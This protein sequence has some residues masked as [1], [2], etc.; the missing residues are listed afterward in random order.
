MHSGARAFFCPIFVVNSLPSLISHQTKAFY[1]YRY[2]EPPAIS[3]SVCPRAYSFSRFIS[4][5]PTHD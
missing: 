1:F 5:R 2:T 4:N 3:G